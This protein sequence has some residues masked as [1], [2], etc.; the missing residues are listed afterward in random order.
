MEILFPYKES[1]DCAKCF[2]QADLK[3]QIRAC[4]ASLKEHYDEFLDRHRICLEE[5]FEG[6]GDRACCWSNHAASVRPEWINDER[7]AQ[8]RAVLNKKSPKKYGA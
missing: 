7:C 1:I 3:A 8:D 2:T 4:K 6:N 5:F